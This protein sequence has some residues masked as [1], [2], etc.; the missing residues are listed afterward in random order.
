MNKNKQLYEIPVMDDIEVEFEGTICI[1]NRTVGID[2]GGD[3]NAED[4]QDGGT[5][6][7]GG[8]Y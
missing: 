6:G 2:S 4:R 1:S 5:W 3:D 8:W 7:D